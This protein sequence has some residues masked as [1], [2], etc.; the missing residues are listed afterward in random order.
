[1]N[2]S[3]VTVYKKPLMDN[4]QEN[5]TIVHDSKVLIVNVRVNF[6]LSLVASS[7][8]LLSLL[9]LYLIKSRI[10]CKTSRGHWE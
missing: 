4:F 2:S 3:F 9:S 8:T 7:D 5:V 1:M 10:N 6:R